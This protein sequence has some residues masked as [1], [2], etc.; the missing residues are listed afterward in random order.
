M[1]NKDRIDKIVTDL[2]PEL[3]KLA[4]DIHDNPELGLEEFK[5]CE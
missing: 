1:N 4:K 2:A 3:K 5:A